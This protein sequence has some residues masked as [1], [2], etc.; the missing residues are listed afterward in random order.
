MKLTVDLLKRI[1]KRV[2]PDRV[3][4]AIVAAK[5]PRFAEGIFSGTPSKQ[6]INQ[7]HIPG[8]QPQVHIGRWTY[9]HAQI[10][11]FH[12]PATLKVG[13]FCSIAEGVKILLGG[14]HQT[15]WVTTYPFSLMWKS[16][17]SIKLRRTKGNVV[18]G[19]DVWIGRDAIILSGVTI[20]DGAIVGAG[21]LVSRHVP[22][23]SIVGGNPAQVI[24]KRF[25]DNTI[26]RL[27][28]VSW[29]DWDDKK[30]EEFLP[31]LMQRNVERFFEALKQAQPTISNDNLGYDSS[32]ALPIGREITGQ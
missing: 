30:I 7:E 18:I 27:L 24:R 25:D 26:E 23:Y 10:V 12:E 22:P 28:K 29:W 6:P 2:L 17:I 21:A 32:K 3:V 9:G 8:R 19:N 14:E 16:Q 4:A 11:W 15:D 13:S 20:G 31:L 5:N 1:L